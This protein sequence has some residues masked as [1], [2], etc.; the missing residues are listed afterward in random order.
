MAMNPTLFST[1]DA[2]RGA[3]TLGTTSFLIAFEHLPKFFSL[4]SP[5]PRPRTSVGPIAGADLD[6]SKGG[7]TPGIPKGG[8]TQ[9]EQGVWRPAAPRS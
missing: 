5:P 2:G 3:Q 1:L 6:I 7:P 8:Y 4:S 9:C